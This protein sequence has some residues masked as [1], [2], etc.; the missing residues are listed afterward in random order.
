MSIDALRWAKRQRTDSPTRKAVLMVLADYAD[1]RARAWPSQERIADETELS[2]RSVRTAIGDLVKLGFLVRQI[3]RR[4][5]GTRGTD[6][7]HLQLDFDSR[8]ELP[9]DSKRQELPAD[10]QP[11]NGV[12]PTGKSRRIN[13]QMAS[14]QP[15][16]VAGK[17]PTEL[18]ENPHPNGSDANA[19]GS[20]AS[21]DVP[22]PLSLVDQLWI[23][24]KAGMMGNGVSE[25]EAGS[26]IGQALKISG[27]DHGRVLWAVTEAIRRGSGDPRPLVMRL[28]RGQPENRSAAPRASPGGFSR[29]GTHQVLAEFMGYGHDQHHDE[30][31]DLD[32]GSLA[33]DSADGGSNGGLHEPARREPERFSGPRHLRVVGSDWY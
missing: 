2:E 21:P 23:E 20:P 19:S 6:I 5:D 8:K 28:I 26:V 31:S 33:A 7:L 17:L 30:G 10:H 18:P 27:N 15:A 1:E 3:R 11:A 12:K 25:R 9:A 14:N 24:G 32:F 13:R 22:L 16:A 29:Q 4:D